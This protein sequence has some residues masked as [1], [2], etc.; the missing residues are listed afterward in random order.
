M[1]VLHR[2][3]L[4]KRKNLLP[5]ILTARPGEDK[6]TWNSSISHHLPLAKNTH[7]NTRRTYYQNLNNKTKARGS[8]LQRINLRE[9]RAKNKMSKL[10]A[11]P[12]TH[13]LQYVKNHE[14]C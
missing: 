13:T 7:Q 1:A 14:G 6:M 12:G 9:Q 2:R 11:V 3:F 5:F 8:G 10:P 4:L